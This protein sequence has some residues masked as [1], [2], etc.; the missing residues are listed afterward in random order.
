MGL[1]KNYCKVE[2]RENFDFV[3]S[4]FMTRVYGWMSLALILTALTAW[5]VTGSESFI[6]LIYEND[7][8][9]LGLFLGELALIWFVSSTIDRLSTSA[10]S[11]LYFLCSLLNGVILAFIFAVFT[12]ES[13]ASAFIVSGITFGIMNLYSFL[14]KKEPS[15]RKNIL[16]MGITGLII[17][18]LF[19]LFFSSTVFSWIIPYIGV[20]IFTGLTVY[21]TQKLKRMSYQIHDERMIGKI[22]LSG[23]LML[24]LDFV[25][26]FLFLLQIIG[27]R[28]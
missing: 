10:V 22:A 3:L 12:T 5:I 13:I 23:S 4:S 8:A 2:Q 28:R 27:H 7:F 18:S 19:N 21:D 17:A 24:Y 6:S 26:L 15:D 1:T 14:T 16:V 20:M 11:F 25:N 9:V